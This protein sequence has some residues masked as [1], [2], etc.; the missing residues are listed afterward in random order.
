M[1]KSLVILLLVY[2]AFSLT[3]CTA[4]NKATVNNVPPPPNSGNSENGG[5][6]DMD[7]ND[8]DELSEDI[9]SI[10]EAM[11]DHLGDPP[12][13]VIG[14]CAGYKKNGAISSA[15]NIALMK[16]FGENAKVFAFYDMGCTPTMLA[17]EMETYDEKSENHKN[18]GYSHDNSTWIGKAGY[19]N[20]DTLG[21]LDASINKTSYSLVSIDKTLKKASSSEAQAIINSS[22]V[23]AYWIVSLPDE[24]ELKGT[25]YNKGTDDRKEPVKKGKLHFKRV[26]PEPTTTDITI[27]VDQQGQYES[28]GELTAGH[29]KVSFNP[30]D[31]KGETIIN[32]NWLYI[33]GINYEMDWFVLVRNTYHIIYDCSATLSTESTYKIHMEWTDLPIDWKV[34][35]EEAYQYGMDL[36]YMGTYCLTYEYFDDGERAVVETQ[37]DEDGNETELVPGYLPTVLQE[38]PIYGEGQTIKMKRPPTLSFYKGAQDSNYMPGAYYVAMT[39]ELEMTSGVIAMDVPFIPG[40]ALEPEWL[41]VE[42]QMKPLF[43]ELSRA[44]R[45]DEEKVDALIE[46]EQPLEVTY[47]WDNGDYYK[48][49]IQIQE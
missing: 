32:E 15:E 20:Y 11:H 14:F 2:L 1:K 47:T 16:F 22:S 40:A 5:D 3:A 4:K 21:N 29:Y 37:I 42:Q 44:G 25:V 28:I 27:D 45:L 30:S 8:S 13:N 10:I 35:S 6:S 39:F 12:D 17:E 9:S 49:I 23:Y 48:M 46:R 26:G 33:P 34:T 19:N 7:G 41:E 36:G 43:E 24:N 31:G 38:T 18:T